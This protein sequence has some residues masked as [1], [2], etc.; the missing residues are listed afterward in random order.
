MQVLSIQHAGGSAWKL[1]SPDH[2]FRRK[3]PSSF[4]VLLKGSHISRKLRYTISVADNFREAIR[5]HAVETF[6]EKDLSK[7]VVAN[8]PPRSGRHRIAERGGTPAAARVSSRGPK[9]MELRLPSESAQRR[10]RCSGTFLSWQK[11]AL[12]GDQ[13]D[14]YACAKH[15]SAKLQRWKPGVYL[16][17]S[18]KFT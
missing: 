18:H 10:G 1:G 2:L 6:R 4:R 7:Q 16:P 5:G 14:C 9:S 15:P 13:N 11:S 3:G 17:V 12:L 8:Q